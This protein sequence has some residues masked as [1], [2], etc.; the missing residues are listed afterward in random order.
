M[1]HSC[2]PL[3]AGLCLTLIPCLAQ[4]KLEGDLRLWYKVTLTFDGPQATEEGS[5]NPFTDYRL[6]VTFTHAS[7]GETRMVPGYFAADGNAAETSAGAGSKWR[8]HFSPHREG[9][10]R[11]N[12]NFRQGKG[13]AVAEDARAGEPWPALDGKTGEFRIGATSAQQ[14]D[15]RARGPLE[16]VGSRYLRFAGDQSYFLKGGVDSP[17]TL[18]GYADF[19]GTYRD[20]S[21]DNRPKALA[22]IIPLPALKEG[23]HRYEPHLRDWKPGD[24]VWQGSKGKGLIGGLNYLASQGINSAYFLTM[25]VIGDGRNV[26]PWIHP[27]KR[28]RFDCSKLDQWE[29]VFS[30]MTR[31]GI[32]LHVVL[33]E[34]ENDNLLDRGELGP[35]RKL[36]VREMVARFAHHP[37]ITWNLGEENVQTVAQQKAFASFI[38]RTDP[39]RHHIVIHNDHWHAKNVRETFDPLLG[40][41]PLTGTALQD[42]Y[43][44]DVYTHVKHFV[45][46]SAA[47]GHPWVVTA[48]E[49]G[50]ANFGTFTDADDPSHDMPRRYGLWATLMA[51]GAGVEWYFGW[52]NASPH[53]DLS[54][55]DWRTRENMYRQT[56]IALD[57][58]HEHLPFDR[59]Q[60]YEDVVGHG[61]YALAEPG[62]LYA[63]YL[64]H[65]GATRF[66]LGDQPGRYEVKWFDPRNGGPLREGSTTHLRGPGPAWTGEP[67]SDM[68]EDWLVLVRRVAET[69]PQKM[70]FPVSEWRTA[71]PEEMGVLPVGLQKTLDLWRTFL[72]EHGVDRVVIARRGVII[73]QGKAAQVANNIYSSTKSFT[74]TALGLLA[75][76]K[77]ISVDAAAVRYEPLLQQY[78]PQVTLRHFAT[79]TSGYN[80]LGDSRWGEPSKD[81]SKEPYVPAPPLF[82]P[83]KQ[84]AYW[85]EAQMMFGRILTRIAGVDLMTYLGERLFQPL[86][87]KPQ[88]WGTEGTVNG[89]T[90]RNGCTGL[91]LNALDLARFG[92][93]FLNEGNWNGKQ[94]IPAEWAREA[95]RVQ[96]GH[97]VPPA[98]TDRRAE[99]RGRYGLNWWV[100]GELPEGGR[101]LPD[102]PVRAY[103]AA[104]LNHNICLVVPEWEMVLVRL[105]EDG[106][107]LGGHDEVLNAVL[108]KLAPAVYPLDTK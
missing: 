60:P 16:Y 12:V 71:P 1:R 49:L 5:P 108:R 104:G 67:P 19:D 66:H 105:G 22:G 7:S 89:I 64:P 70:Q 51:G 54:A 45:K 11:W 2:L 76:E 98:D 101:A 40:F 57:F 15:F 25:N 87:M 50:G 27:W 80:A 86:G 48:D 100:N 90:I 35:E 68:Y 21:T 20:L 61:V 41:R 75:A 93:L 33:Q 17:E 91:Q 24:P 13:V 77:G 36:Y 37:A 56:R 29:I 55:E 62:K 63:I 92:H 82:P 38:R 59:L 31:L 102:A 43:W 88:S 97:D 6:D 106:R 65:G 58:F 34:T 4:V 69:A 30:H 78:Y 46:A 28:D 107:Q 72:G 83:G 8:V 52:Q 39:Y 23:L 42:F 74:S 14:P 10:W 96:V 44:N 94:L 85:D 47:T 79:M 103:Y 99:G 84:F 95:T 9:A 26:W 32:M 81:W 3:A 73:H 53:S 18:L